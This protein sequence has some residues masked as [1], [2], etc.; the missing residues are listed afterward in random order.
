MFPNLGME[1]LLS[2]FAAQNPQMG[3]QLDAMGIPLPQGLDPNGEGM[4]LGSMVNP[5]QPQAQKPGGNP[6]QA[7]AGMQGVQAPKPVQPIMSG[8]VAGG[9]KPPEVNAKMGSGSPAIAALMQALLERKS[10][11]AVPSLGAM[12]RGSI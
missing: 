6:L 11:P 2:M 12:V 1:G 4:N 8:G 10:A 7:L 5:G 3:P 9:V